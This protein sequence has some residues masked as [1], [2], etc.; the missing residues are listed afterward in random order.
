M[1]EMIVMCEHVKMKTKE[2]DREEK[3]EKE[4]KRERERE[5]EKERKTEKEKEKEK[6]KEE[7][8]AVR[9]VV[10]CGG[11]G[12]VLQH[13]CVCGG[14]EVLLLSFLCSDSCFL[15]FGFLFFGF[16]FWVLF[17]SSTDAKSR[18]R[19]WKSYVHTKPSTTSC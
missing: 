13:V 12:I 16:L 14:S 2:K 18:L 17:S 8:C 9:S 11:G 15:F 4:R 19:T 6:E 10:V 1:S 7:L 3:K 5:R